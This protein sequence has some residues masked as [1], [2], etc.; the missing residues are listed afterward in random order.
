MLTKKKVL[1]N[2][3]LILGIILLFNIIS[4][5]FFFRL[6]FTEDSRYTLN[7][8]T[9]D[10]LSSLE[11]P[12]TVTAYFSENMPPNV[13]KVKEDFKDMLIEY[14]SVSGGQIQY[15]FINPNVDQKSEVE[16]QRAGIQPVMINVRERDQVKQQRAYLGAV[17]EYK[18]KKEIIPVIQPGAAMEYDLSTNIKKLTLTKK[19]K[20][21]FLKGNGE[22]E[23][24]AL[25]QL[26][27]QLSIMYNVVPFEFTDTTK[28]TNDIKT[29]VILAPAD[30]LDP[31]YIKQI[32]NYLAGGGRI[33]VALN[34]V[35]GDLSK[36]R[37]SL[38]N[39][40]LN[41][42]LKKFGI[43]V[44]GKFII[45]VSSGSVMVRQNQGEF[46][47]S[48]PVKFPY[49]PI[50]T[51]FE[52]HPI[53]KGIESVIMQ[54][55][56]PITITPDSSLKY[57]MFAKTSKTSGIETPPIYFNVMKQ[58]TRNDF[59]L[60]NL[61]VGVAVDGKLKNNTYSKMVVFSDGD[62]VINGTGQ[63]TRQL[64]KDNINIM[65][66]AIDWLS[67]DTG[68]IA[69]RTKGV[70][71]KPIDATLKQGTKTLI[72]YLNFLLPIILIIIYGLVR[73][74]IRKKKRNKWMDERYV[75]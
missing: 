62:F 10:I 63:R 29:L 17:L 75:Q 9:K 56:S 71:N 48:T 54:F 1:T 12:V 74:Q 51:N 6:D 43:D 23:L 55:A 33:L 3:L 72:K 4:N 36:A 45:D 50:I 30:T 61:S 24:S 13:A 40:G 59:P 7:D 58:W 8:A 19:T 11:D 68:L 67:D 35:T 52:D 2:I 20:I 22:P 53:S 27:Q 21:A 18:E 31:A 69:L 65:S 16:A 42:W 47:M 41:E 57:T 44:E 5:R 25:Q 46:V 64:E 37:G 70:T 73:Y 26:T 49:L 28:L 60:S 34:R 39:T 14:N 38:K 15:D 66:N 32:D